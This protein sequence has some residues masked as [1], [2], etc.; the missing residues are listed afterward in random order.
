MELRVIDAQ[1][2]GLGKMLI[3]EIKKEMPELE[4]A[5]IG[6]NSAATAAMKK[7]GAS[8]AAT[9]E[10]AIVVSARK[11]KVI[12]GPIGIILADAM[13]GEITPKM[14][15]AVASSEARLVLIPMNRCHTVIVGVGN[16][17][18]S[19]YIVEAVDA[20][21]NCHGTGQIS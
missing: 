5:A 6:T 2:V 1:G 21:L 14:A 9:G 12:A 17:K 4:V 18:L 13:M 7:A 15:E 10:N 19:E 20:V 8:K 11:A 3:A 16:K